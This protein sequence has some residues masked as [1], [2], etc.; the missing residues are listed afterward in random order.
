[1]NNT[2]TAEI[3]QRKSMSFEEYIRL[4]ESIVA[5]NSSDEI[6]RNEKMLNYT[7]DNLARMNKIASNLAIDKRLYNELQPLQEEQTWVCITEPWCGD[8]SQIVPALYLIASCNANIDFRILL[9]DANEDIMNNYLTNGGKS[10]P[11]LI[12][13]QSETLEEIESWGPR[14]AVIQQIVQEQ[15]HDTTTSFGDKV[16]MIHKWYDENNSKDLQEEFITIVKGWKTH[17]NA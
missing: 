1:M 4:T 7:K 8:A 15:I 17:T 13:L 16:R 10:I 14:P 9:R 12:M 3:L 11:K 5:G 6:Y 2:I